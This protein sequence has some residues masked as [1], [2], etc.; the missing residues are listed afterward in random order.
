MRITWNPTESAFELEFDRSNF[1]ND[2]SAAKAAK[3]KTTGPP[4][5]RWYTQKIA[6]LKSLQ[7]NRPAILTI[8]PDALRQFTEQSRQQDEVDRLR[9]LFEDGKARAEG[10]PTSDEKAVKK[11]ER[12]A[13]HLAS[14]KTAKPKPKKKPA[15]RYTDPEGIKYDVKYVPWKPPAPPDARCHFCKDP[16]YEIF[17][18]AEI[19]VCLWCEKITLD[20]QI[21]FDIMLDSYANLGGL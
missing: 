7:L 16:V 6:N 15:A 13:K 1:Q 4:D 11:A 20:K 10:K 14:G 8:T 12:L 2:L 3:F 5:W 19:P 9:K 18:F 17:E 21:Q